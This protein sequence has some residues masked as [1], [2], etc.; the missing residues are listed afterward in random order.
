[1]DPRPAEEVVPYISTANCSVMAIQNICLSYYYCF[2][3]KLLESVYAGLPVVAANLFELA[4]F[5]TA[6][7]VGVIVDET[8]AAAVAEGIRTVLSSNEYRPTAARLQSI[9][10]GFGWPAQASRLVKIYERLAETGRQV[11]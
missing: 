8:S 7:E 5:V 1:V 6:N 2:P 11:A 4:R 9:E 10:S 3:N